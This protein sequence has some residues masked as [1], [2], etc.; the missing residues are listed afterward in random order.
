MYT[1]LNRLQPTQNFNRNNVTLKY[2][3]ENCY[4]KNPMWTISIGV[5]L[6]SNTLLLKVSLFTY[7]FA[8]SNQNKIILASKNWPSKDGNLES[9]YPARTDNMDWS[10]LWQTKVSMSNECTRLH[11]SKYPTIRW[12]HIP[13]TMSIIQT[14]SEDQV[15]VVIQWTKMVLIPDSTAPYDQIRAEF[16]SQVYIESIYKSH[17][18][19]NFKLFL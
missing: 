3:L 6:D 11:P 18:I 12:E 10:I 7:M 2:D 8:R 13:K 1:V 4:Q 9:T 14:N 5:A 16:T 19:Q 17:S 15:W